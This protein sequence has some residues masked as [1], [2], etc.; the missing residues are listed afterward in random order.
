MIKKLK[1]ENFDV[2]KKFLISGIG[3]KSKNEIVN[4]ISKLDIEKEVIFTRFISNEER[5]SLYKNISILKYFER[6]GTPPVEAMMLGTVVII[7][8]LTS[9]YEVAQ[10]KAYYVE[11][12]YN[13]D[14]WLE[15][16]KKVNLNNNFKNTSFKEYDIQLIVANYINII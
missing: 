15:E 6:V 2:P 1:D 9:I 11:D 5:N 13:V 16:I 3:E 8:K 10:G 4:L 14:E 7:M 12:P